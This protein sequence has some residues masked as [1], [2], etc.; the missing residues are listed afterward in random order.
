M[1]SGFC[2]ALVDRAGGVG[3][4]VSVA[5]L[6]HA[7]PSNAAPVPSGAHPR[8][9]MSADNVAAFGANAGNSKT[10]AAALVKACQDTI[11]SPNDFTTRGGSDGDYWPGSAM[12]CAFAYLATQKTQYLTQAITYW[13]ASLR[14]DQTIDDK[15]GCMPGVSTDWT[16]WDGNPPAPPV[17]IT[18]THDTGYP[19]RWYAPD[20]ALTYDWLYS[21]PGVDPDL[22][23]QTRTC[24][25]AWVDYYTARGYHADEAG[26]NYNA[27]YAIGK[28]LAAIAIGNDGGADGHLWNETTTALF[29]TLLIGQ[30]LSGMSGNVGDA[31]GPMVGGDWAEGWQY[32]PLSVLEYAVAARAVEENGVPLPEMDAWTDSIIVRLI[33]GT[34]PS[35]DGQWVGGDFDSDSVFQSP[36]LNQFDAVLAGPSTD[37]AAAWAANE[38]AKA[39]PGPGP[40]FYNALAEL[41]TVAAADYRT[42]ST[43]PAPWY[44]ARGTRAMYARTAWDDGAYWSVFSSAPAVVSDHEHFSASNFV[45][46]RGADPLIVDA[47]NYG[48]YDTFA[49]NAVTAD[50]TVA[51]GDYIG[52]QTPWSNAELTWAR[53]TSDA[54][55]AARSDFATAFN[56]SS[57]PSDIKYAHREW[58]MLPE[59][60]IVAIDRVHTADASHDMYV[61]FHTNTGGGNLKLNGAI[62]SGPAGASTVAIHTVLLSGGTPEIKTPNVGDC[63]LSCSYPCG[64][65]DAAR[66]AIDEYSVAVPGP[67]AVAIHAI[68]GLDKSE[69]P[70]VVG[71]LNDDTFDP[72]PKQNAG[73]IGAAVQRSSKLS[74]VVA[75][76]GKDGAVGSTMTYGVPGT[77]PSRNVVFDAPEDTNGKSMVTASASNGRCVLSITAGGGFTGHP[78]MFTVAT[79]ADGCTVTD[80]TNVPA[81]SGV[82]MGGSSNSGTGG[83][84]SANGGASNAGGSGNGGTAGSS[85]NGG[86]SG[87]N[88]GAANAGSGGTSAPTVTSGETGGA[89]SG[90][91]SSKGCGC[92]IEARETDPR[93]VI[94]MLAG[95]LSLASLRRRRKSARPDR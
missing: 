86:T 52:T 61:A 23:S 12:S 39:S 35:G 37:Q 77:A 49:T 19:M 92:R 17:I 90:S 36:A 79:A 76:S 51:Q 5:L 59:G 20:I 78:L 16:G 94:A 31:A 18:V 7:A 2:G 80:G 3:A 56:Y 60:E 45:F 89:S 22:L 33:H 50:S 57:T 58:V 67:W 82:G 30:G 13:N 68:D 64:Q 9:F 42:Q 53:G 43:P 88:G 41:R 24:L 95:L 54:T 6:A 11:D 66:F 38:K 15:A 34:D 40:Y 1:G 65:C 10:S 93:S 55:Y 21:A 71:S 25:T 87:A 69:A 70:A 28:T 48:E 73:V 8:L 74:Y 29:P 81:G 46:N 14:D 4:L 85:N 91:G 75:S 27:G 26:A 47:S 62:A 44:L 32:G 63:T 83:T 84:T 72:A